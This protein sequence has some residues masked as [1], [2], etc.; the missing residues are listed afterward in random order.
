MDS[1]EP[2]P[3][4]P[5][6]RKMTD[7]EPLSVFIAVTDKFARVRTIERPGSQIRYFTIEDVRGLPH[8]V[9]TLIND[10]DKYLRGS[11][12]SE[13]FQIL[14]PI[15]DSEVQFFSPDVMLDH[16]LING[17]VFVRRPEDSEDQ[18]VSINNSGIHLPEGDTATVLGLGEVDPEGRAEHIAVRIALY[19]LIPTTIV[20]RPRGEF[21]T[22]LTS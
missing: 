16:L 5:R 10:Y 2:S 21:E 13:L 17:G 4:D 20:E 19:H 3:I 11:E 1:V 18:Y 12:D 22:W 7:S 14:V 8:Y 9:I 15:G 6:E